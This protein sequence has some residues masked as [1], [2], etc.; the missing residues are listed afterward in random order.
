MKFALLVRLQAKTGREQEVENFITNALPLAI[1]EPDTMTWYA[2][3]IDAS[4]FGIFDT[5]P[6]EEGRQAHLSGKIANA[7]MANASELLAEDP[8]IEKVDILAAKTQMS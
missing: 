7:L 1:D 2:I 3:K 6:H 5:F 4:T 8:T